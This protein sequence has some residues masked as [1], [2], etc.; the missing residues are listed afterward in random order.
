MA[1]LSRFLVGLL[2]IVSLCLSLA[3]CHRDGDHSADVAPISSPTAAGSGAVPQLS[4]PSPTA[5]VRRPTPARRPEEPTPVSEMLDPTIV[6]MVNGIPISRATF[7]RQVDQARNQLLA[8]PAG[9]ALSPSSESSAE[10]QELL[11]QIEK[12]VLDW[13]I[14]QILIEQGA[15][16][17]G[18]V[19]SDERVDR[20]IRAMQG[21]DEER[22]Q[23]WLTASGLTLDDLRYQVRMDLLTAA[24]RD[25]I[26]KGL[27]RRMVQYHVRHIL[28][29]DESRAMQALSE[30][31]AGGNFIA[32]ARTYSEDAATRE[33]GGDIGFLPPGVMP[34]AFEEATFALQPGQISDIVRTEMG[35]HIIQLVEIDPDRPIDDKY[36]PAVQ[37]RAFEEWL[38]TRRAAAHI[39]RAL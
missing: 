3:S 19:I 34:P 4:P 36:W 38:A 37:Q 39:Q 31:R 26:T 6:A 22:F 1:R 30:L 16:E 12:Q 7:E 20:R 13:M 35:L 11:G 24:V 10:V 29:S 33:S 28:L 21:R 5:T 23:Q 9:R 14:D 32:I 18:F 17:L 15:T 8:A 27:S 25:H 2:L